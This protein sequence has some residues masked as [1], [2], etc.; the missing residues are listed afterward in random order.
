MPAA[1]KKPWT[2]MFYLVAEPSDQSAVTG[3]QMN[4]AA[5]A[6]IAAFGRAAAR[7][8][9]VAHAVCQID[10]NGP[11]GIFRFAFDHFGKHPLP[12]DPKDQHSSPSDHD[13]IQKFFSK[14][15]KEYPGERH[16]A[17]F[18]G[19]S[20]GP[21]GLFASD[22][23]P[24]QIVSPLVS[25]REQRDVVARLNALGAATANAISANSHPLTIP[26]LADVLKTASGSISKKLDLVVFQ[27]CC[28]NTLEI[29]YELAPH[30]DFQLGSQSQI[31]IYHTPPPGKRPS[32]P[33]TWPYE[34]LFAQ[35]ANAIGKTDAATAGLGM[36]DV[37]GTF[38][39]DPANIG[40]HSPGHLRPDSN[41]V[42]M[43]LVDLTNL[44]AEVGPALND[45]VAAMKIQAPI[46]AKRSHRILSCS[47]GDAALVDI[48]RLCEE[49]KPSGH[50]L[51]SVLRRHVLGNRSLTHGFNGLSLF[52]RPGGLQPQGFVMTGVLRPDYAALRLPQMTSWTDEFAFEAINQSIH[53]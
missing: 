27:D 29:A 13:V 3:P 49:F 52:Y 7:Y 46:A 43:A 20:F 23:P 6:Q 16:V 31:P 12:V 2:V 38:F 11:G 47:A 22:G 39:H 41:D 30:V 48:V 45:F 40:P 32:S 4:V 19:H 18:W 50:E 24:R 36:L 53:T 9:D 28:M 51:E 15:S 25:S 17:F 35:L 8:S 37:L 21:G 34:D 33:C 10:H 5:E 44:E 14:A 26:Q 1:A 42:P